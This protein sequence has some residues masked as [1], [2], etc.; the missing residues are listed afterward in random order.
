MWNFLSILFS[1]VFYNLYSLKFPKRF[2][3]MCSRK[4]FYFRHRQTTLQFTISTFFFY[5]FLIYLFN[6]PQGAFFEKILLAGG[7]KGC[8]LEN[9]WVPGFSDSLNH[10]RDEEWPI[11]KLIMLNFKLFPWKILFSLKWK[12]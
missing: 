8:P 1:A 3:P 7:K 6:E 12:S 2:S 9:D 5:L 10:I 4:L 11:T